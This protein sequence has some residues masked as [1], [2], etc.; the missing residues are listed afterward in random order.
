MIN[1]AEQPSPANDVF[2]ASNPG[3]NVPRVKATDVVNENFEAESAPRNEEQRLR[4][5]KDVKKTNKL[6]NVTMKI[7]EGYWMSQGRE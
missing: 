2:A 6:R 7:R 1:N 5:S 3:V 4:E